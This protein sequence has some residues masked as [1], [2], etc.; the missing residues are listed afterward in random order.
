M[1]EVIAEFRLALVGML[2]LALLFL[3][4]CTCVALLAYEVPL[5]TDAPVGP[6]LN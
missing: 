4:L 5:Q 6:K 1:R 2:A 3:I